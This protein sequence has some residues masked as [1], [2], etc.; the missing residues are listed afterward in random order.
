MGISAKNVCQ[1]DWVL[2]LRVRKRLKGHELGVDFALVT[3]ITFTCEASHC[4]K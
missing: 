4:A 3:S 1:F 2:G